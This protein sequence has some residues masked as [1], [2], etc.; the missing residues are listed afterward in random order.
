MEGRI[1]FRLA[2]GG[3]LG[4]V[5]ILG[6]VRL[7]GIGIDRLVRRNRFVSAPRAAANLA[8][9][10]LVR[11]NR[12]H[13]VSDRYAHRGVRLLELAGHKVGQLFGHGAG[14][15][16]LDSIFHCLL[17]LCCYALVNGAGVEGFYRNVLNALAHRACRI[18][19]T[20]RVRR[21]IVAG[22][23]AGAVHKLRMGVLNGCNEA[24][25]SFCQV[26]RIGVPTHFILLALSETIFSL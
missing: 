22:Q 8:G 17:N 9:L 11:N 5:R 3:R 26:F 20:M 18:V 4:F 14:N 15:C 7:I 12:F 2:H 10:D 23:F 1:N 13:L 25:D 21:E 19:Q 24:Y 16:F 6:L